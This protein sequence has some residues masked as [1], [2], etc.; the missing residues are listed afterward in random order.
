[1]STQSLPLSTLAAQ[2]TDT[3]ISAPAIADIIA[4]DKATYQGIFGSDAVLT[5]DTQDGQ[6]IAARCAAINDCNQLAIAVYNSFSPT[7]AQGAGLSANVTLNGIQRNVPTNST[8]I[9]TISGVAG[10]IIQDGAAI[11]TSGNLWDLPSSVTIPVSGAITVTAT[12]QQAGAINAAAGTVNRPYTIISGWQ[13]VTNAAAAT[14]GLA[15]ETDA[16]LRRRQAQSTALP[17]TSPLDSIM[18]AV[19]NVAGVGRSQGYENTGNSTDANGIPAHSI[20]VVVEGGD[21]TLIAQ[22][23]QTKKGPGSGTYGTTTVTV[24]DQKGLPIPLKF[25][26]LTETA[27]HAA[28]T[29]QP[30]TGYVS[31]TGTAAVAALVGYLNSLGIGNQVYL[32]SCIAA[33]SLVGVNDANGNLL[34]ATFAITSLTIGLAAGSLGT[35]DI[36]ISFNAAAQSAAANVTLTTL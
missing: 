16:A 12:A 35:A 33:A 19:G 11:D 10:T 17:A 31:T 34:S 30:L 27:I 29:I 7:Y 2:I 8:V 23:I 18:A 6:L 5:A 36:P 24:T 28:M 15:V 3:G 1:M 13:S 22:A 14:P 4:S 25:F 9:L 21:A 20:A 26:S 32:N